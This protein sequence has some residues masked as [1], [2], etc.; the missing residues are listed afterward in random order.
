MREVSRVLFCIDRGCGA[1]ILSEEGL[2]LS[3]GDVE[4]SKGAESEEAAFVGVRTKDHWDFGANIPRLGWN[5][6]TVDVRL[7]V[8]RIETAVYNYKI[9]LWCGG[10]EGRC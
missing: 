6:D 3:C 5:C 7:E 9:S 2:V 1:E 10:V 4:T 8:D